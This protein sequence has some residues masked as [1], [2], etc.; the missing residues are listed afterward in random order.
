MALL[1]LNRFKISKPLTTG[2]QHVSFQSPSCPYQ[3]SLLTIVII[4]I[5][6]IIIINIIISIIIFTIASF[7]EIRPRK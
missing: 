3:A 2:A 6:I 4:I 1:T 7:L 5:I